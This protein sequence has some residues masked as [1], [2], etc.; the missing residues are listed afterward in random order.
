MKVIVNGQ[1]LAITST[2]LADCCRNWNTKASGWQRPS[3]QNLSTAKSG[4]P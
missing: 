2:N 4:G 3:M 1:A